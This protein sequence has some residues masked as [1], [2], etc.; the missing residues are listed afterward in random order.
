MEEGGSSSRAPIKSVFALCNQPSSRSWSNLYKVS[1]K[2]GF[3]NHLDLLMILHLC[4]FQAFQLTSLVVKGPSESY[5]VFTASLDGIAIN[6]EKVKKGVACVQDFVRQRLITQ[7]TF[8]SET[9]IEMLNTAV[10]ATDA[11]QHISNFDHWRAIGVES[12]LVIANLKS[13]RVKVL[14]RRK[15]V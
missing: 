8:F 11:V 15:T 3:L 14:L 2:W 1:I 12:G 7:T 4:C 9:V 10:A 6:H 5:P 13:C